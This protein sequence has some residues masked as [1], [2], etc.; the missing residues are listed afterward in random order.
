M[1]KMR[2]KYIRNNLIPALFGH[3]AV[4]LAKWVFINNKS[5]TDTRLRK[6]EARHVYQFSQE[7]FTFWFKYLYYQVKYGYWD[8]PYEKDARSFEKT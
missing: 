1:I 8:N 7:P 6:H 4:T 5:F 3:D 2:P